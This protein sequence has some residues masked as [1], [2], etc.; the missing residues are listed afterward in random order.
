MKFR[1][2]FYEGE[3]CTMVEHHA[4]AEHVAY[5]LELWHPVTTPG[6]DHIVIEPEEAS[7]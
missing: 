4:S 7:S 5:L 3:R 2:K 1:V 6:V